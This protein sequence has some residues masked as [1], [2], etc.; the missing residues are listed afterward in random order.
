MNDNLLRKAVDARLSGLTFTPQM[1]ADT[2][3]RV[4]PA[5]STRMGRKLS[6][7]LAFALLALLL[8]ATAGAAAY[9]GVLHFHGEQENNA[10]YQRHILPIGERLT[11]QTRPSPSTTRCSTVLPSPSRWISPTFRI[12]RRFISTRA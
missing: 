5:G 12:P 7:S 9:F 11:G 1:Q 6:Y 2:L 10:V 4:H 3:R 8:A